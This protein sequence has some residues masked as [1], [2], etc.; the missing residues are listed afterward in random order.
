M[1]DEAALQARRREH[2]CQ[3]PQTRIPDPEAAVHLIKRVG[4]ATLFPASPEIP[5]LFHAYVGDPSAETSSQWDSP[6]GHV[7]GSYRTGAKG[8]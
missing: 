4:I 2:W 1:V 3:T 5:N 8:G 7:Y 6:S